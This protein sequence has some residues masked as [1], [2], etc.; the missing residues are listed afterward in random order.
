ME[1]LLKKWEAEWKVLYDEIHEENI[2]V[3]QLRRKLAKQKQLDDCMADL[4]AAMGNSYGQPPRFPIGTRAEFGDKVMVMGGAYPCGLPDGAICEAVS[5]IDGH[6]IWDQFINADIGSV[7][8]LP[9]NYAII[10]KAVPKSGELGK[11][12]D[13]WTTETALHNNGDSTE[14]A[15][16]KSGEPEGLYPRGTKAK[17]GQVIKVVGDS[18]FHTYSTGDICICEEQ[19]IKASDLVRV[20]KYGDVD[21]QLMTPQD[22]II[23]AEKAATENPE[24]QEVKGI[25]PVGTKAKVGDKIRIIGCNTTLEH[26]FNNGD[27]CVCVVEDSFDSIRAKRISDGHLQFVNSPDYVIIEEAG[28]DS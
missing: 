26:D 16:E 3:G 19:N 21:S 23:I 14:K 12:I 28:H 8:L 11:V 17:E 13:I 22:Y 5:R 24:K 2:T 18:F 27:I 1:Q 9:S 15:A 10:E 6:V 20:K 7:F 4:K 25:H